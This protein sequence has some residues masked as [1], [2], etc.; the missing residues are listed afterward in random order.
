[1]EARI[2]E[3]DNPLESVLQEIANAVRTLGLEPAVYTLLSRPKRFVEVNVAVEMDDGS[4]RVFTGYR[5]QHNDA[6]G[7]CKGGIRFHPGVT[8]DEVKALSAWMTIKCALLSLPFGGGKGGVVCDPRELSQRELEELSRGYVRS[9]AHLLGPEVDIPAPDV[10]TNPQVMAWMAD[11]YARL[12][13]RASFA[14]ITGKPTVIGGSLGRL[15]ATGRGVVIAAREIM[16]RLGA[17]LAG[18]TVAV[19]GFGNVGSVAALL[20]RRQGARVV[21]VSDSRGGIYAPAGLDVEAVLRH[22][23]A[24]GGVTGFPGAR[25]VSNEELLTLACDLLVPAALENVIHGG[26]AWNVQARVVAEAANGPTTPEADAI[27]R[28]RGVTVIPDVL[29]NAGGVTVSYFEWV[30]NQQGYYWT[31]QEVNEQLEQFLAR[32][33]DSVW[34]MAAEHGTDLRDAAYLVA[35]NRLAEAM[36]VRGWLGQAQVPAWPLLL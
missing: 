30:Q 14:V 35:V 28:R 24:T 19:Q 7:P 21:A 15:E 5:S 11:E 16:R 36:R 9:L 2:Q 6:L 29:A 32:A 4:V 34:R 20:A 10:Y 3:T 18:A 31:E 33:C 12:T 27:L 26:N 25:P 17:D 8:P 23:E 1:M 13:Q 22:K